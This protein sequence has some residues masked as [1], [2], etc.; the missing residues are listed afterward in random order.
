MQQLHHHMTYWKMFL[1]LRSINWPNF[2]VWLSLL[3]EIS[4]NICI[5]ALY[6]I[7]PLS[8]KTEQ[9]RKN[10]A[11]CHH[12]LNKNH[13]SVW[14]ENFLKMVYYSE[15]KTKKFLFEH[16]HIKSRKLLQPT[17]KNGAPSNISKEKDTI[18]SWIFS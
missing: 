1:I 7:S 17:K 8:N 12:L 14:S 3:L 4:D 13:I 15:A 6:C 10:S 11:V 2:I 5:I 9:P 16:S 18:I